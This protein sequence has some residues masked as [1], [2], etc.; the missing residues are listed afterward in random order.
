[1][2]DMTTNLAIELDRFKDRIQ[3]DQ[4]VQITRA[5]G[6]GGSGAI[7]W[8]LLLLLMGLAWAKLARR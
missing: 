3:T 4:S 6:Y 7:Q 8:P 2:S 5:P 1:M